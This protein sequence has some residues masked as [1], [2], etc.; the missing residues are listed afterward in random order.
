MFFLLTC[1]LCSAQ[2]EPVWP[3]GQGGSE[4]RL[5]LSSES[6]GAFDSYR[7]AVPPAPH[8]AALGPRDLPSL[9]PNLPGMPGSGDGDH[10]TQ[11][12]P[13]W[14]VMGAMM[15]V[16]MVAGGVYLMR[17]GNSRMSPSTGV[18]LASPAMRAVPVPVAGGG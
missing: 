8:L 2:P 14:V 6:V 1:A 11:M 12:S 7:W 13:M 4:L 18:S 10:S 17:Q 9:D 3:G 15:V 16:M 5:S